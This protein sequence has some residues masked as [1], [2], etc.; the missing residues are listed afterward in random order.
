MKAIIGRF[1]DLGLRELF[2]LLGSA[3]VTGVL[4]VDCGDGKV[5]LPV[6]QG[7]VQGEA[8]AVLVQALANRT[9]AFSFQPQEV[10]SSGEWRSLEEFAGRVEELAVEG[11]RGGAGA[12]DASEAE[13]TDPLAELRTSL[14]EVPLRLEGARVL[15]FTADPRPYR[16]L[17]SQWR[18]RGWEVQVCSEP[19][20]PADA[21]AGIV[22]LHLPSSATLAGQGELW[23]DLVRQAVRQQPPIPVVWVGGLAD[24]WLRHQAILAGADFLLPAPAGEVGETARWFREELTLLSER[25]LSRRGSGADR[26]ANA[27]RE[28]FLALHADAAPADVRASLLRFA[29]SFFG[30]GV[31]M[32][33]RDA[34]FELLGTYGL[35]SSSRVRLP[36]GLTV[37]EEIV[38]SR[39]AVELRERPA[40]ALKAL[41]A[42]L[43]VASGFRD[44]EVFP[45]LSGG[46]CVALFLGDG[47][48]RQVEATTSL[49][50][51]LARSGALLG[52]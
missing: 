36:R 35:P 19:S 44:A 15:V 46:R 26:E 33:A 22:L 32:A 4:E 28:F 34:N 2:R 38:A 14:S 50:T 7:Y 13:A 49:A 37:L 8:G 17:A 51:L 41:A 23:L 16:T 11:A 31:L 40:G 1:A 20:W 9:G 21:I 29:G 43:G 12:A 52:L 30:R 42:A 45:L 10:A 24:P 25:L 47:R 6:Q 27:F 39:Q 5:S 18:D 3:G 48:Q